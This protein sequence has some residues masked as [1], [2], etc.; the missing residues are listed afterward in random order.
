VKTF[1][2]SEGSWELVFYFPP[3]SAV[4]YSPGFHLDNPAR[5]AMAATKGW[6]RRR[7]FFRD[8][9]NEPGDEHVGDYWHA[10]LMPDGAALRGTHAAR[11]SARPRT[12]ARGRGAG[13]LSLS[14]RAVEIVTQLVVTG[15]FDRDRCCARSSLHRDEACAHCSKNKRALGGD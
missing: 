11:D 13:D 4:A 10:E 2:Q 15:Q 9:S 1:G 8:A 14:D 7:Q 3:S 12:L 6:Y 5:P